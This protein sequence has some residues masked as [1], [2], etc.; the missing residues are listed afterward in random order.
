MEE[1]KS[2]KEGR[3]RETRPLQNG[4][5]GYASKGHPVH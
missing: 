3:E 1:T 2:G 5:S 4:I